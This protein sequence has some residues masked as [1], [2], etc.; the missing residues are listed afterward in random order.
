MGVDS[1]SHNYTTVSESKELTETEHCKKID[2]TIN[3]HMK[4][5]IMIHSDLFNK[6]K[7]HTANWAFL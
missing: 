3:Q 7:S 4:M 5:S 1:N 2:F 6:I